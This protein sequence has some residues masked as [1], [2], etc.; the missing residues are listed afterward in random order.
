MNPDDPRRWE[1]S[2]HARL[3][4][5]VMSPAIEMERSLPAPGT[6][7]PWMLQGA[8]GSSSATS[9]ASFVARAAQ[10]RMATSRSNEPDRPAEQAGSACPS[11]GNSL[12][13]TPGSS[14]VIPTVGR[15]TSRG[16]DPLRP[17][18]LRPERKTSGEGFLDG[19]ITPP[20]NPRI[21]SPKPLRQQLV[22]PS[23]LSDRQ[24]LKPMKPA[25]TPVPTMQQSETVGSA[26]APR[27]WSSPI[28]RGRGQTAQ[29]PPQPA[30]PLNRLRNPVTT[31]ASMPGTPSAASRQL[32]LNGGA[33][34]FGMLQSSSPPS[35]ASFPAQIGAGRCG[36]GMKGSPFLVSQTP[37]SSAAAEGG[38]ADANVA[39]TAHVVPLLKGEC[40][41]MP[42]KDMGQQPPAIFNQGPSRRS[43]E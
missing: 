19:E 38:N 32:S 23:A 36:S 35:R 17:T 16:Q 22:A 24:S 4:P 42:S 40:R 8:G 34:L 1:T 21:K 26:S 30:S 37:P 12:C 6:S 15:A 7:S 29:S 11:A 28:L 39:Q 2:N 41:P 5:P 31:R 18:E 13:Q 43:P 10:R 20:R 3:P 27:K 9:G 33:H 14:A 25:G